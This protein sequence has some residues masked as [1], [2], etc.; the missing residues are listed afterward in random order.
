MERKGS[1]L[2]IQCEVA[3][4]SV[5]RFIEPIQSQLLT[6]SVSVSPLVDNY[7]QILTLPLLAGGVN[8]EEVLRFPH[9]L[10]KT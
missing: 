5:N 7:E 4:L 9:R 3:W 10:S 1:F 8:P 6:I 2:Q